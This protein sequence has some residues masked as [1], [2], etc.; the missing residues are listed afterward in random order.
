MTVAE[1]TEARAE[2][3]VYEMKSN[4]VTDINGADNGLYYNTAGG[5]IKD[6]VTPNEY[7]T[8]KKSV[9]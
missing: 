6:V 7:E 5:T 4:S 9:S 8:V 2:M 1:N 3:P